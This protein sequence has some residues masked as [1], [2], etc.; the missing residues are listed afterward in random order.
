MIVKLREIPEE[1]LRLAG[2]ISHDIFGL[3]EEHV[4]VDGPVSYDLDAS[5]LG[6]TILVMGE[7]SAPFQLECGRCLESFRYVVIVPDYAFSEPLESR[8]TIDLTESIRED[9]LLALPIHPLCENGTP[10]REC[11]AAG[12]FEKADAATG[13]PEIRDAWADLEGFKPSS[14]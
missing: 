10:P 14:D 6:D 5:I 4:A 3:T 11:P 12:Q 8:G 7:L 1:G 13:D 2:E 9:I